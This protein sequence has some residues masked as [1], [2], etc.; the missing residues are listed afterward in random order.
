VRYDCFKVQ[1]CSCRNA[2][3]FFIRRFHTAVASGKFCAQLNNVS[4]RR[5]A[6][7]NLAGYRW[8]GA[9]GVMPRPFLPPGERASHTDWMGCVS[10]RAGEAK[11]WLA[12]Q[13]NFRFGSSVIRP[14]VQQSD[15]VT[16]V[17]AGFMW[18]VYVPP[19]IAVIRSCRMGSR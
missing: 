18:T 12:G 5:M 17:A 10:E 2:T 3:R 9:V 4:W 8:R 1:R 15:P 13:S 14:A 19:D 7:W 16:E 6:E 11:V